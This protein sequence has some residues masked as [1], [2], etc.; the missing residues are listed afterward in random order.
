MKI[1]TG[2]SVT[3]RIEGRFAFAVSL[4]RAILDQL[5]QRILDRGLTN[6]GHR[7]HDF[8]PDKLTNFSLVDA[9]LSSVLRLSF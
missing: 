3:P 6:R 2:K 1:S 5:L 9:V 7:L 4:D 8:T